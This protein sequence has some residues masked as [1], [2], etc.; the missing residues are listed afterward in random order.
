LGIWGF[1]VNNRVPEKYRLEV[2]AK[3]RFL[4]KLYPNW[5]IGYRG[6]IGFRLKWGIFNSFGELDFGKGGVGLR[7]NSTLSRLREPPCVKKGKPLFKRKR[8]HFQE[9]ALKSNSGTRI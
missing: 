3:E 6:Q 5:V 2:V 8:E 9:I 4:F 7:A 1:S